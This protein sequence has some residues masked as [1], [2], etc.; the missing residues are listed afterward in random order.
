MFRLLRPGGIL[1]LSV[2][3][4][5]RL[6]CIYNAMDKDIDAI[7]NQLM[8]GQDNQYNIHYTVF[9]EKSMH[10]LLK[11]IGFGEVQPWDAWKCDEF[12]VTDRAIR[13]MDMNGVKHPISLNLD[14]IK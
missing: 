8:G 11:E 3:D 5:D 2:P 9:T 14:A 10:S 7:H 6:L 12:K 4:F 13:K 1:R